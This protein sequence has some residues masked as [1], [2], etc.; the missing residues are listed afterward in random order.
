MFVRVRRLCLSV[1]DKCGQPRDL[2]AQTSEDMSTTLAQF[3]TLRTEFNE[4]KKIR[5]QAYTHLKIAV[6]EI[7]AYGRFLFRGN[8]DRYFGYRS[9]YMR[10]KKNRPTNDM[11]KATDAHE[12]PTFAK[13][14]KKE[15]NK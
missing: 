11:K 1:A 12:L 5:D 9:Q 7:Y 6:D 4:L 14:R 13:K 8:K 15:Y 2:A 10:Q 3:T